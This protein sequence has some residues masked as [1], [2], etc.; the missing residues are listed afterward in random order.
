[1][2]HTVL[3][4]QTLLPRAVFPQLRGP[5]G[6]DRG[7]YS[8]SPHIFEDSYQD[9]PGYRVERKAAR[10]TEGSPPNLRKAA[11]DWRKVAP[12]RCPTGEKWRPTGARPAKSG[13]QLAPDGKKWR[14]T[15]ARRQKVAPNGKKWRPTVFGAANLAP[16]RRAALPD[17][18]TSPGTQPRPNRAKP[19]PSSEAPVVAAPVLGPSRGTQ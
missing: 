15:G 4:P 7:A 16:E 18:P 19:H 3:H 11:P 5:L 13:A 12:E 8:E 1:M 14:P 10:Q 9:S 17:W 6:P 2:F